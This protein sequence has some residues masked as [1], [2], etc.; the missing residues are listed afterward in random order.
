MNRFQ[1]EKKTVIENVV[2][3]AIEKSGVPYVILRANWFADNQCPVHVVESRETSPT[4]FCVNG[5][6]G[7]GWRGKWARKNLAVFD[8]KSVQSVKSTVLQKLAGHT[9]SLNDLRPA[10]DGF[11]G[12]VGVFTWRIGCS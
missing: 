7:S 4:V 6:G 9:E 10:P 5:D 3:I 2:E 12:D 1:K 11:S 8:L